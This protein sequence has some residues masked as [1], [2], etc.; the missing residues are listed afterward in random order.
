MG[1]EI[2]NYRPNKIRFKIIYNS[3]LIETK[4]LIIITKI[5]NKE[6]EIQ[7]KITNKDKEIQAK[8]I[9]NISNKTRIFKYK[10]Q[11]YY[12]HNSNY[13]LKILI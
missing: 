12:S 5:T 8:I 9:E 3:I 11:T 13:S 7:A 6:I 10:F 1:S 4:I 2:D